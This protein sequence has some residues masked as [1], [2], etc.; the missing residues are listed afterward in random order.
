MA[1]AARDSDQER[2]LNAGAFRGTLSSLVVRFK[3]FNTLVTLWVR[4]AST[5][6]LTVAVILLLFILHQLFLW[7][8][9]DPEKAF[10]NAAFALELIEVIWDVLGIINNAVIDICNAALIPMW[11]SFTYYAVEPLVILILE[12][13]SLVFFDRHY[14]GV[15]DETSFPYQGIDCTSSVTAMQWC[16][17][18]RA[19]EQSLIQG[20]SG[21]VNK[22]TIFLG[23]KTARR[24]SELSGTGDF[25]TPVFDIDIVTDALLKVATLGIVAVA[26]L[27][28]IATAILDDVLST[29]AVAIFDAV[30]LLME[31]I[32]NT[33][34]LLLCPPPPPLPSTPACLPP[35]AHDAVTTGTTRSEAL[36]EVG[37]VD[38]RR[39][40]WHRLPRHLFHI[41]RAPA[42]FCRAGFD[43]VYRRLFLPSGMGR[44]AAVCEQKLF[45]RPVCNDGPVD[46]H[47]RPRH[48]EA[49]WDHIGSHSQLRDRRALCGQLCVCHVHTTAGTIAVSPRVL[50][51]SLRADAVAYD[52]GAGVADLLQAF[53]PTAAL[54]D[55]TACFKCKVS[56]DRDSKGG[57]T[58]ASSHGVADAVRAHS[59]QRYGSCGG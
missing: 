51:R 58:N 3:V 6:G 19:Y 11:N 45:Q 49:V 5:I 36:G 10:D 42:F 23:L 17:R 28:D 16:G 53:Y 47:Q 32:L 18:Y 34:A 8:D 1:M 21:F 50:T 26:P 24:L 52:A 31:G 40:G 46:I 29:A 20:E 55:C 25:A 2:T 38:V 9:R 43:H 15:I 13:F 27:A 56:S 44:S 7:V 35:S 14:G 33:C 59:F 48:T 22:S 54:A 12:I 57:S 30:W 4:S 41:L 39:R 37:N